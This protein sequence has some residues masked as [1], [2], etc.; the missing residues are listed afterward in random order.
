MRQPRF[1]QIEYKNRFLS[2][3]LEERR[4]QTGIRSFCA[5][6]ALFL[7]FCTFARAQATVSPLMGVGA[8]QFL[9][10]NGQPISGGAL[11]AYAAGT[12]TPQATYTDATGTTQNPNPVILNGYG[13]ASVW[14]VSTE[15]YKLIL[16]LQN[17]GSYCASGDILFSVDQVPG[18]GAVAGSGSPFTGIFISSTSNPATSGILRLA[19]GDGVCWRNVAG[20]ANLCLTLD[21]NNALNW[22]GGTFRNPFVSGASDCNAG[23]ST[24]WADPT[25]QRWMMCNNGLAPAQ[26]VGSGVDI[27]D[28]DNVTGFSMGA[29]DYQFN[30][31]VPLSEGDQLAY[32]GNYVSG[33]GGPVISVTNSGTGTTLDTLTILTGAPSTAQIAATSSPNTAV[34]GITVSNAGSTGSAIIQSSGLAPCVFDGATT[35]GDYIQASV[36]TGGDCHDSGISSGTYSSLGTVLSTNTGAGTYQVRF[37]MSASGGVAVAA[38]CT[39]NIFASTPISTTGTPVALASGCSVTTP[40]SGC[41]CR[42]HILYTVTLNKISAGRGVSTWVSSN[43]ADSGSHSTF[44]SAWAGESNASDFAASELSSSSY[45]PGTWS[46]SQNV[47]FT[48]YGETST[49]NYTMV[50]VPNSGSGPAMTFQVAF[51]TSN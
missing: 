11:Y 5:I 8:V 38:I 29:T 4:M 36:T 14:L 23:S 15:F 7:A 40:S 12:T 20:S 3:G 10:N 47:T 37:S 13:R 48:L 30:P 41:P 18:G 27:N 46:N 50:G 32:D 43:V 34:V 26:V 6:I 42:A 1:R 9:N 51:E 44:A 22:A 49:G 25:A 35:A 16:C 2:L 21:S 45:S 33:F 31:T 28:T 19:S 17:D 39:Q 24:L